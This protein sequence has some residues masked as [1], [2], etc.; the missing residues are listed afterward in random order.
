MTRRFAVVNPIDLELLS[1]TEQRNGVKALS[2][3]DDPDYD[4]AFTIQGGQ[5]RP[6][7]YT[8]DIAN[9]SGRIAGSHSVRGAVPEGGLTIKGVRD[10]FQFAYRYDSD[11]QM[12]FIGQGHVNVK[13]Y[14]KFN[15]SNGRVTD[16]S[17]RLR[18]IRMFSF[19]GSLYLLGEAIEKN[20]ED[21]YGFVELYQ[22]DELY[23]VFKI[24]KRFTEYPVD[25]VPDFFEFQYGSPDW[26]EFE[27]SLFITYKFVQREIQK[28][29]IVIFKAYDAGIS[30]FKEESRI[31]MLNQQSFKYDTGKFRLRACQGDGVVMI[32]TYGLASLPITQATPSYVAQLKDM[33]QYVSFDGGA[34][35]STR[36][37]YSSGLF[38]NQGNEIVTPPATTSLY[39]MF[40]PTHKSGNYDRD[41]TQFNHNFSLFFDANMSSFVI[42][43]CGDGVNSYKNAANSFIMAVKTSSEDFFIWEPCL[44]YQLNIQAHGVNPESDTYDEQMSGSGDENA[45]FII[46]DID[47]VS[48]EN[49]NFAIIE[50]KPND[51]AVPDNSLGTL[52][53]AIFEFSFI[54]SEYFP[55]GYYDKIFAYGGKYHEEYAFLCT[56]INPFN[57]GTMSPGTFTRVYKDATGSLQPVLTRWRN[58]LVSTVRDIASNSYRYFAVH[59]PW[60]NLGE[61]YGYESSYPRFLLDPTLANWERSFTS[62]LSPAPLISEDLVR[63]SVN[64]ISQ[65]AFFVV[66]G[67]LLGLEGT[68]SVPS[69]AGAASIQ[70]GKSKFG[71]RIS[72]VP[73]ASTLTFF[74]MILSDE[75]A[76]SNFKSIELRINSA[77]HIFAY[78]ISGHSYGQLTFV[79]IDLGVYYEYYVAIGYAPDGTD[80]ITFWMRRSGDFYWSNIQ[81]LELSPET[82]SGVQVSQ[83][84]VGIIQY[85]TYSPTMYVDVGDLFIGSY[86]NG[87]RPFYSDKKRQVAG[88]LDNT[89][90]SFYDLSTTAFPFTCSF[91]TSYSTFCR[92]HDGSVLNFKGGKVGANES[93]SWRSA[94]ILS[95]N[96]SANVLSG[97]ADHAYDFTGLDTVE[98]IFNNVNAAKFDAISLINVC[99]VDLIDLKV[100][101][102]DIYSQ[103]WVGLET[104]SYQWAR[105][106]LASPSISGKYI[107]YSNDLNFQ[108]NQ[109]AG[110]TIYIR[111]TLTN[112]WVGTVKVIENFNNIIKVDQTISTSV[113]RAFYISYQSASFDVPDVIKNGNY[114]NISLTFTNVTGSFLNIVGEISVGRLIQLDD[115]VTSAD[116]ESFDLEGERRSE[117]GYGF[118]SRSDN[119]NIVEKIKLELQKLYNYDDESFKVLSLLESLYSK[120]KNFPVIEQSVNGNA[121]NYAVIDQFSMSPSFPI[122]DI[123][124][125]I[126]YQK[127]TQRR[128]VPRTSEPP[129][130][131]IY[132]DKND[133]DVDQ[134][135]NFSADAVDPDGTSV[136]YF[137]SFG[138]GTTS[139]LQNP[140][141]NYLEIGFYQVACTATDGDGDQSTKYINVYVNPAKID[142]YELDITGTSPYPAATPLTAVIQA[143][144]RQGNPVTYDSST[145]ITVRPSDD[146]FVD[147]NGDT[148]LNSTEDYAPFRLT[149]GSL[150]FVIYADFPGS[151]TLSMVDSS[152]YY[153]IFDIEF[154]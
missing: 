55:K 98:L 2:T 25:V 117:R 126:V 7:E 64:A 151:Y 78:N 149:E 47:V 118:N 52:G 110:Y 94:R 22:Y 131:N 112:V 90:I 142:T 103:T 134:T 69:R 93:I 130:L 73:A 11:D 56:P 145:K 128:N 85:T 13:E 122:T 152:G 17:S 91:S 59:S 96:D 71:L 140:S 70:A 154:I 45:V 105:Y 67:N 125:N 9:L 34:T 6:D 144:D 44:R 102:Y 38:V 41:F 123:S 42:M 150:T 49:G 80:L 124:M 63:C 111:N 23:K 18:N 65:Q 36:T 115:L 16:V 77:G 97:V 127:W 29:F 106:Q 48:C 101:S 88:N 62:G 79:P 12:Q 37:D 120:E 5:I 46:S 40:I 109:L 14:R 147:V 57:S 92:L 119:G 84:R 53:T 58:Q 83:V 10:P 135:I 8:L 138:D 81:T 75:S 95:S 50:T 89:F 153:K 39:A 60:S 20:G 32:V 28:S 3:D 116:Y 66:S 82:P 113:D 133:I 139:V 100:G 132:S 86:E 15:V 35:F 24:I 121:T 141:K 54:S 148:I 137:W 68:R 43:K 33:R 51:F 104:A 76:S 129:I 21:N 136:T 26:F 31:E 1:G 114:K 107:V 143:V 19:K 30:E 4:L 74:R 108:K 87:Y 72:G 27:G 99:G 61:D 146:M